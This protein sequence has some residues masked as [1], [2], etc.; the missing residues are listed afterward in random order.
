MEKHRNNKTESE[1]D[2]AADGAKLASAQGGAVARQT[3]RDGDDDGEFCR[4]VVSNAAEGA[5]NSSGVFCGGRDPV[6]VFAR[7]LTGIRMNQ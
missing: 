6:M 2:N 5:I 1:R 3:V 4:F 7:L